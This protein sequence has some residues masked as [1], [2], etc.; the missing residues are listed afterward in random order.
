MQRPFTPEYPK[1][2]NSPRALI[3]TLGGFLLLLLVLAW[4]TFKAVA[5]L[6]VAVMPVSWESAIGKSF[7]AHYLETSGGQC[8]LTAP[9]QSALDRLSQP[10]IALS[11]AGKVTL[12]I[13][14]SPA[15]NALAFPGGHVVILRGLLQRATHPNMVAG[16]LAHELGHVHHRH[17]VQGV[18]DK[19]ALWLIIDGLTGG[20]GAAWWLFDLAD[21]AGSRAFEREADSFAVKL[22]TGAGLDPGGLADFLRLVDP[23]GIEDTGLAGDIA[24]LVST[25]PLSADR[26]SA[27][28]AQ[29]T[30]PGGGSSSAD[31][32][33]NGRR[34]I[35][36]ANAWASLKGVCQ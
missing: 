23:D 30:S 16:V 35:L 24:S 25:H 21:L 11:G 14:D 2:E 32:L 7:A 27:I 31:R 18:A 5:W 3:V 15:V 10:L 28:D 19:I 8:T 26:I 29:S 17:S 36:G 13:A 6:L 20:S 12:Y 9:E 34:S 33:S 4:L 22:M 1:A